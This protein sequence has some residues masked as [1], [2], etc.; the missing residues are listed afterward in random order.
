MRIKLH[1]KLAIIFC[2]AVIFA[3]SSVYFYLF[4]RLKSYAENN[5]QEHMQRQLFLGREF[6]ETSPQTKTGSV[7]FQA[8]ALRIGNALQGRATIVSSEG[9]VLGDSDLTR[10][11]L[12]AVDNHADRPEIKEALSRGYGMAKRYSYTVKKYMLY[13]AV[14]FGKE[15]TLGVLRFS[16]ALRDIEILQSGMYKVMGI[17]VFVILFLSLLLTLIISVIVSRPVREMSKIAA[18]MAGGDFSRRCAVYAQD[19]LG[20]LAN[21]LNKMSQEIKDKIGKEKSERAKFDTVLSSMFEGVVV[22]DE[23]ERI[24]LMNSSLRKIFFVEQDP[25]GKKLLEVMRNSAVEEI[26]KRIVQSKKGLVTEEIALGAPGEKVL[27][28]NGVPIIRNDNFDGAILVFHDITA[29][30]RLEQV[31]QDFVAN[32]S[33]ELR[34]PV[35]SIKGYAETLLDGALEDKD[36]AKEFVGII[37][38]DANRLANLINDLLDLSRIESGKMKMSFV[39][40]DAVSLIKRAVAVIENQARAKSI[41]LKFDLPENLPKINADETRFSQVMINILDNAI[42]YSPEGGVAAIFAKVTDK[43][44]QIDISDSGIGISEN[45]LPR[46]FERFYRVDKARSRELGGTGLGLSIVKHIVSAHGGQVWVKSELGKG[47]IFSFT[48][49]LA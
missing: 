43:M 31:R 32:V 36:N 12:E 49:P 5:L 15:K 46:I 19:E 37:Y 3:F 35:S 11:Q 8:L 33:H 28:V 1:S 20:D 16:L 42:K 38:Q 9:K 44:L 45:D 30:R 21:S 6:L 47:S 41:V 4:S 24:V 13:M 29:L 14:P 39:A 23:E 7:D 2:L 25:Q 18:A 26:A 17:G 27:S 40:L 10:E 48:I 22:I 34:T